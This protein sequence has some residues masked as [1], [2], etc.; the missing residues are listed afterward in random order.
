MRTLININAQDET[1]GGPFV[2]LTWRDGAAAESVE[3][4]RYET[5]EAW[6]AAIA[7]YRQ[8]LLADYARSQGPGAVSREE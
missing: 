6:V 1:A 7:H 4:L 5:R 2:E 8:V 3:T